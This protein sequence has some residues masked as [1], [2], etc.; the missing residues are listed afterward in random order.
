MSEFK[1]NDYITLKAENGKTE[2]YILGEKFIQCKF[3]LMDIPLE[4]ISLV[5]E[6][7]SIDET[8]DILN[9]SSDTISNVDFTTEFWAHC[10]NLQAWAENNYNTK[11][12]HRNLAFPLLKKLTTAGDPVAKKV[13]KE[14][15]AKRFSSG[16][17]PVI[18]YLV[19]EGYLSYLD[20]DEIEDALESMP[21][22]FTK[23]KEHLET[24]NSEVSELLLYSF[25]ELL[26]SDNKLLES[27]ALKPEMKLIQNLILIL[28][29]SSI[30]GETAVF[31]LEIL[32][33][34]RTSNNSI[35]DIF[36][37]EVKYQFNNGSSKIIL[38]LI[39][40]KFFNFLDESSIQTLFP[41]KNFQNNLIYLLEDDVDYILDSLIE[42]FILIYDKLGK[43]EIFNFFG[44]MSND[45]LKY[46]K[47]Q[48]EDR[49]T[50]YTTRRDRYQKNKAELM[51]RANRLLILINEKII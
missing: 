27:L 3:L 13:F 18:L 45:I 50:L 11:L 34:L 9:Q 51:T 48:I 14:E 38:E 40:D 19:S 43:K 25:L 41:N 37:N 17:I 29:Y 30:D 24:E 36:R 8:S 20:K 1:I 2:I 47:E 46:L 15:I 32:E 7:G 49:L 35:G 5:E 44:M 23:L 26:N 12:L 28:S 33:K 21:N 31:I 22:I 4:D 10:S 16:F 39:Y 6:I 42:F